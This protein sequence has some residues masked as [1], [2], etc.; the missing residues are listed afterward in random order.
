MI[1]LSSDTAT[2]PTPG[3]YRAM[4]A[5][6]T[7]D[8]QKRA[9]PTVNA[10]CERVAA[11]LGKE[12][13]VFLPSGVMCNNIGILT[14]CGR[15]DEVITA[16]SA[17]IA[18]ME[19]GA[20]AAIAGVMVRPL[21]GA[22][23]Q[24]TS[25]QVASAICISPQKNVANTGLIAIE[26]TS[27]RGGGSIWPLETLQDIGQL[28]R[29]HNISMH[30]DG[31]RMLNAS[32]ATGISPVDYAREFDTCWIDL[33]KGLGCPVGAVL[34]GSGKL[35]EEAWR[36]KHRLG[37]AMRQAG[38]LAA[39]GI[40]ALDNHV[41]RMADDH[42]NASRLAEGLALIDG[43][44]LAAG[45]PETNMVFLDILESGISAAH[46]SK[47][48][49]ESGISIGIESEYRLRAVTHLDVA[50]G[51]IPTVIDAVARIVQS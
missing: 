43:V 25:E 21:D 47:M 48:L 46:L 18:N 15:G 19:G 22:R 50:S 42:D 3:M 6:D 4:V 41:E 34:A 44:T 35:I 36:W 31:A 37:G 49:L 29:G 20:P 28:A 1:D 33:S 30:M 9:D 17:H 14:Q 39:A 16:G 32:V 5:A 13:A 24:F 2:R 26:Q 11:M 40:Y 45:P 23:G 8:E 38:V 10:L 7:G 51:D 12:S 27:N